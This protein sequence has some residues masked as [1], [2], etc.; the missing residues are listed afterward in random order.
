MGPLISSIQILCQISTQSESPKKHLEPHFRSSIQLGVLPKILFWV[1]YVSHSL[2]KLSLSNVLLYSFFYFTPH[3]KQTNW[4]WSAESPSLPNHQIFLQRNPNFLVQGNLNLPA[5]RSKL[6][7]FPTKI[8]HLLPAA[9]ITSRPEKITGN[10]GWGNKCWMGTN[11]KRE[12][13]NVIGIV[14]WGHPGPGLLAA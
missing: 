13:G 4:P 10:V 8:A 12:L 2:Q 14:V 11:G 7:K 9:A 3:K 6:P 5:K 1:P